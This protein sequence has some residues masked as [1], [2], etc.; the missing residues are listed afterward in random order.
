MKRNK[1]I[2]HFLPL[3]LASGSPRRAE[4]LRQ[5]GFKFSVIKSHIPELSRRPRS[6]PIKIWPICLALRKASAVAGKLKHPAI[7]IGADTIVVLDGKIINKAR[8]R[9]HGR[10]ILQSLSGKKHAVITGIALIKADTCR[11]AVA[12]SVCRM[13]KLSPRWLQKY[14]DSGLWKGKAGAYGIQNHDDPVVQLI[15]GEWSN[16]VGLP[17]GLLKQELESFLQE[18]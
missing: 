6:V 18:R 16:V 12:T 8:D 10:Q 14:L 15:S 13:K 3:V 9:A 17:M 2:R 11:L 7:V 1:T 5:A 4:L